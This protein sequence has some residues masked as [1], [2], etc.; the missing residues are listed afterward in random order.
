MTI[1]LEKNSIALQSSSPTISRICVLQMTPKVVIL[2][3]DWV[4]R[5]PVYGAIIRYAE[6]YPVHDGFD[7]LVPKLKSLV[8]RGYSIVVFPE[9]TRS[10]DGEI[11]RFH[12][13]AFQLAQQLG[14]DLLPVM[15]HGAEHV[16]PKNDIV[17]R[18]GQLSVEVKKRVPFD[19]FK[20]KDTRVL[21]SEM[22]EL[23]KA[24]LEEMRHRLEDEKY[25]MPF[26]RYQYMYKGRDVARRARRN[27]N[28]YLESGVWNAGQGE[29]AL[30]KALSH[31]AEHFECRFDNE[32]DY[33][34]AKTIV[35]RLGVENLITAGVQSSTGASDP[36]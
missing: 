28:E 9:G 35:E 20:M 31:K 24:Y 23:M 15:I 12:K 34:I 3:N 22:R 36:A 13:G 4:W 18:E 27:L 17:L 6:F 5:N 29:V 7:A 14:V 19:G 11:G 32:E 25:C 33:L 8:D 2:T 10:M 16:M 26:V 1:L 30:L 21:T